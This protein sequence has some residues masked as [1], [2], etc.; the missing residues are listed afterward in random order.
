MAQTGNT[1]IITYHT[2]TAAAVPDA[3]DLVAGELA[4][5]VTDRKIYTE[6]AGAVVVQIGSGPTATDTFTNKTIN[7]TSNTLSGTTAQFNTALSD[8]DFATLAGAED[9]TNK[10][11]TLPVVNGYTEGSVVAN[12]TATYTIDISADSVQILTLTANCTYTF[13]TADVGKSFL[14]IQ[15]Q[16]GTGSRTATWPAAVKWPAS[17]APTLTGT[18]SKADVFAF[19][20]DGTNWYG[21]VIGQ[22][23]L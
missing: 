18:A 6:N 4:V 8:G 17:T 2:A 23:Y 5:N 19:T 10:T 16:D 7:L 15:K 1:A 20:S 13:P 9:L 14:L 22:N 21:R 12:T 11:L 3:A